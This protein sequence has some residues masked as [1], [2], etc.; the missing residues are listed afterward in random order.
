MAEASTLLCSKCKKTTPK[1]GDTKCEKCLK[2]MERDKNY[3]KQ[4]RKNQKQTGNSKCPSKRENIQAYRDYVITPCLNAPPY[5]NALSM[6]PVMMPMVT[7]PNMMRGT[8]PHSTI[9]QPAKRPRGSSTSHDQVLTED[10]KLADWHR[11]KSLMNENNILT[12]QCAAWQSRDQVLTTPERVKATMD[13]KGVCLL[14]NFVKLD[15]NFRD[16]VHQLSGKRGWECIFQKLSAKRSTPNNGDRKRWQLYGDQQSKLQTI[17]N[18]LFTNLLRK[19]GLDGKQKVVTTNKSTRK[20]QRLRKKDRPPTTYVFEANLLLAKAGCAA[21]AFHTDERQHGE[22][23]NVKT[24]PFSIIVGVSKRA[25]LDVVLANNG[26]PVRVVLCQGDVLFFRGDVIHR[27]TENPWNHDNYRMHCYV[28]P[29]VDD[30]GIPYTRQ[31]N[32]TIPCDFQYTDFDPYKKL[33]GP[34]AP[35]Y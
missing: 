17:T 35:L 20:S 28:D 34:D 6:L 33:A 13:E 31:E 32:A 19:I 29:T 27:G 15:G 9:Q 26:S 2:R 22:Y 3:Q 11:V 12:M 7:V 1:I 24:Y 4:R 10:G 8:L 23:D 25:Y 30:K 18:K 16:F 5:L 14:P 21:Q